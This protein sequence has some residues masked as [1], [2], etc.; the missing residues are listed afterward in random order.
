[1]KKRTQHTSSNNCEQRLETNT[2]SNTRKGGQKHN[3]VIEELQKISVK[4]EGPVREKE[5]LNY[6]PKGTNKKRHQTRQLN[7]VK[8]HL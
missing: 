3:D 7:L 4:S 6:I 2:V 1:M 8:K 5:L